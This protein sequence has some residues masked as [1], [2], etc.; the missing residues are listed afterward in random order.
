MT[1]ELSAVQ[2]DDALLDNL[3]SAL[4]RLEGPE[5]RLCLVLMASRLVAEAR[6]MPELVDTDTATAT[7]AYSVRM[8][9]RAK[10]VAVAALVVLVSVVLGLALVPIT[11]D[12]VFKPTLNAIGLSLDLVPSWCWVVAAICV[13]GLAGACLAVLRM[14]D[15]PD[16]TM[17]GDGS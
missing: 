12:N 8:R 2:A 5:R 15:D 3:G 11:W 6:P 9:E 16:W 17:R 7:I 1:L 10:V 14:K 4:P 13:S